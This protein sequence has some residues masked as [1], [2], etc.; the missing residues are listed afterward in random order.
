MDNI[1]STSLKMFWLFFLGLSL[2]P[3]IAAVITQKLDDKKSD[4][5]EDEK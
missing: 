2:L 3:L 5:E 4:K 1:Y